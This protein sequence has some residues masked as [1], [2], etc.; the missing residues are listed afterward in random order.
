MVPPG[1][2][3]PGYTPPGYPP[4]TESLEPQGRCEC[5]RNPT[6]GSFRS[7][8]LLDRI[9]NIWNRQDRLIISKTEGLINNINRERMLEI[10]EVNKKYDYKINKLTNSQSSQLNSLLVY[11]K[12]WVSSMNYDSNILSRLIYSIKS[13][14]S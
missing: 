1:Y 3:P 9:E 12:L 2:T 11:R 4:P 10:A 7:N 14:F 8:P 6:S 5:P 13:F